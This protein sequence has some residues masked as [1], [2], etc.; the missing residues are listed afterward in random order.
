MAGALTGEHQWTHTTAEWPLRCVRCPALLAPG[1]R[2]LCDDCVGEGARAEREAEMILLIQERSSVPQSK[3]WF[4]RL[5]EQTMD[6]KLAWHVPW[7]RHIRRVVN[8]GG[9]KDG[10]RFGLDIGALHLWV[11]YR[12]HSKVRDGWLGLAKEKEWVRAWAKDPGTDDELRAW[13]TYSAFLFGRLDPPKAH[14]KRWHALRA[15][16]TLAKGG[17]INKADVIV[18][19]GT[20]RASAAQWASER[21]SGSDG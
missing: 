15:G 1:K 12:G 20:P 11:I 6:I 5:N 9:I 7:E 16:F 10:W 21:G 8:G 2:A 13:A 19:W 3:W 17:E 4:I 14:Q 18:P